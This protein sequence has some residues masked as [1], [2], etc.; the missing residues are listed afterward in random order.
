MNN[1]ASARKN[2]GL[3]QKALATQLN[4]SQG[5]LSNWEREVHDPDSESL[6]RMCEIFDTTSDYLLGITNDS[7]KKSP[8]EE[9]DQSESS[10]LD[11]LLE[12]LKEEDTLM[13]NGEILTD[14]AAYYF[15]Q[16]IEAATEHVKR[17][18]EREKEQSNV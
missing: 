2:M 13:F 10:D 15:Q 3:S 7:T 6:L 17:L 8:S 12:S 1:I 18:Q 16:A 9:S 14:E 4:V 11:K 5:T